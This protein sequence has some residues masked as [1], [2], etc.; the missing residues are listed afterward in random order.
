VAAWDQ[1]LAE[2]QFLVWCN[3]EMPVADRAA[4][5]P[6]RAVAADERGGGGVGA[7]DHPDVTEVG[8]PPGPAV[9]ISD[10]GSQCVGR[11]VSGAAPEK[12]G[13]T[14]RGRGRHRSR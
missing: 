7:L 10:E 11:F 8:A 9:D 1:R 14:W 13:E 12:G 5:R 4:Q 3:D 6:Q 2:P